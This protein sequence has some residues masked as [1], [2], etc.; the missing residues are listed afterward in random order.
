MRC[1]TTYENTT[2]VLSIPVIMMTSSNGNIFRVAGPLCGEFTGEFPSQKPLT[3][4]FD[5]FFDLRLNKMLS[6]QSWS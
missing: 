4:A 6:K 3:R 5:V 1:L 2:R